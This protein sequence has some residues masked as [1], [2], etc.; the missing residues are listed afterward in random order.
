MTAVANKGP[1][2]MPKKATAMVNTTSEYVP[3]KQLKGESDEDVEEYRVELAKSSSQKA[4]SNA[5]R[6]QYG[7]KDREG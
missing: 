1:K 7:Q 4:R 5:A 3:E 6:A 2:I